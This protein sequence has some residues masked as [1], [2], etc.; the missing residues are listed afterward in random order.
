MTA[1]MPIVQHVRNAADESCEPGV[2]R[3]VTLGRGHEALERS[4]HAALE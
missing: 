1:E 3:F 4:S 2:R